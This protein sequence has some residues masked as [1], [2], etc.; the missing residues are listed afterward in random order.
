MGNPLFEERLRLGPV[1]VGDPTRD[2]LVRRYAYGIPGPDALEAIAAASPGGVVELGA[3]TGYWARL[4]HE[5]GVDVVAYD[6]NP[7][8]DGANP[9]FDP[10]P[11]WFP[12]R[13]GNANDVVRHPTRTLLLVW[14]TWDQSWPGDAAAIHHAA[15]GAS[16][17]FVGDG[18][19][20]LTGDSVLH[21]LLGEYGSCLA[22]GLGVV[23]A[24]C[25]C[26]VDELWH[27]VRRVPVARWAGGSDACCVYERVDAPART[28]RRRR[29]P[30]R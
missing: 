11:A 24:P 7:T 27:L 15:G 8:A 3:G 25:L 23:D 2:R 5:R 19:G 14:P 12:V 29:R 22:C 4:L 17:V 16:L 18:P 10:A 20:G 1:G 6:P 9:S 13:V 26:A 30:A 28:R 21:A